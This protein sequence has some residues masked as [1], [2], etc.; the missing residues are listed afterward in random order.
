MLPLGASAQ[1]GITTFGLQYKPIIPNR[2]IGTYQQ[3]FNIDQFEHNL[4]L[5]YV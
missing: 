5:T 1:K 2:F 3:D 4:S